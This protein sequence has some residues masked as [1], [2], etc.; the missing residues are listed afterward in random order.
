MKI[1][2]IKIEKNPNELNN[3]KHII[4]SLRD[5]ITRKTERESIKTIKVLDPKDKDNDKNINFNKIQLNSNFEQHD[6]IISP[7]VRLSLNILNKKFESNNKF[8][9]R[10]KR[11]NQNNNNF[12]LNQNEYEDKMKEFTKLEIFKRSQKFFTSNLSVLHTTRNYNSKNSFV[13]KSGCESLKTL[14]NSKFNLNV[15]NRNIEGGTK[16]RF[17]RSEQERIHSQINIWKKEKLKYSKDDKTINKTENVKE[18]LSINSSKNLNAYLTQLVGNSFQSKSLN[19]E[20]N[21]L[22]NR[23]SY[24][25]ESEIQNYAQ[26][27]CKLRKKYH[28]QFKSLKIDRYDVLNLKVHH[29]FVNSS[30]LKTNLKSK[31]EKIVNLV[32]SIMSDYKNTKQMLKKQL[33]IEKHE[34][35]LKNSEFKSM[36]SLSHRLFQ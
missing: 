14:F 21:S 17:R 12:S 16:R 7:P 3:S 20:Q 26:K 30:F 2:Q 29:L 19:P 35:L 34:I 25:H 13:N 28:N 8:D 4:K 10:R 27:L 23:S 9:Q 1:N 18:S 5:I 22:I 6:H 33:K 32:T 24:N 31:S 15:N 11:A 36:N